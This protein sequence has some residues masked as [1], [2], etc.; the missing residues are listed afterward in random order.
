[1]LCGDCCRVLS[2]SI[3]L[4]NILSA[5]GGGSG[6]GE[7]AELTGERAELPSPQFVTER[8]ASF[9]ADAPRYRILYSTHTSVLPGIVYCIVHTHPS[10]LYVTHRVRM[11][12]L[13]GSG[14]FI[15]APLSVRYALYIYISGVSHREGC[16]YHRTP[17]PGSNCASE[18]RSSE[19]PHPTRASAST[20]IGPPNQVTTAP[21]NNLY[22]F[23]V[24]IV[25]GCCYTN[26]A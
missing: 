5:A 14:V 16:G 15:L 26:Q 20:R 19:Q 2:Y 4:H 18:T 3:L 22:M 23:Y 10:S 25:V 24:V 9:Y 11:V 1:M 8:A 13:T 6:G 17:A 12:Y 21:D 7:R